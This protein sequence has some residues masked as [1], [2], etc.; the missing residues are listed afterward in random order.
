MIKPLLQVIPALSGNVKLACELDK[1]TQIDDNTFK[2]IC[3]KGHMYPLSS[4]M[5]QSPIDISLLHSSWE[6]DITHFYNVYSDIFF[7]NT[8]TYDKNNILKIYSLGNIIND[9][10]VDVE[11]GC[12][13]VSYQ[14]TNKQLNFF[15]PIYCDNVN[16]IPDYF[17]IT[18]EI[19]NKDLYK[20]K[21]VIRVDL[22]KDNTNH[23]GKYINRYFSKID[24]NVIYMLPSSKQALYYGIDVK[25]GGFNTFVDNIISK[26][27]TYETTVNGYDACISGGFKRN[28]LIIRQIMPLAYYFNI[29]DVLTD[30][31][32]LKY[33]FGTLKISGAYYK[34]GKQLP[35]YKFDDNYEK[36]SLPTKTIDKHTGKFTNVFNY[37]NILN[38]SDHIA[39]ATTDIEEY[40]F[41]NKLNKF[42]NRWILKYSDEKQP[43]ITN[44][45]YLFSKNQGLQNMYYQY[46]QNY[47]WGTALCNIIDNNIN[48]LLPIGTNIEKYYKDYQF[49][50][51]KYL[52]SLNNYVSNWF[53]MT[54]QTDI[55]YILTNT[56]WADVHPDGKLLY[57]GVLYDFNKMYKSL[58]P[59]K[60]KK[61]DKFAILF[62]ID[63]SELFDNSTIKNYI[64]ADGCM[65]YTDS[66]NA[67]IQSNIFENIN[68]GE[69]QTKLLEDPL[70]NV[71]DTANSDTNHKLNY[72]YELNQYFTYNTSG[73]GKY[74]N[75]NDIPLYKTKTAFH[76]NYYEYN[77][78]YE[79]KDTSVNSLLRLINDKIIEPK[80]AKQYKEYIISGYVVLEIPYI[81]NIKDIIYLLRADSTLYFSLGNHNNIKHISELNPN[82]IANT[83]Q[84]YECVFYKHINVIAEKNISRLVYKLN[85]V[86]NNSDIVQD[87]IGTHVKDRNNKFVFHPLYKLDNN[88][89]LNNVFTKIN[90]VNVF[91]EN[92]TDIS[93]LNTDMDLLYVDPYKIKT[94]LEK[95]HTLSGLMYI[96]HIDEKYI[97]LSDFVT[98]NNIQLFISET[99]NKELILNKLNYTYSYVANYNN[100]Y[101]IEKLITDVNSIF[102]SKNEL[103]L[104]SVKNIT[105]SLE[106]IDSKWCPTYSYTEYSKMSSGTVYAYTYDINVNDKL[107][108]NIIEHTDNIYRNN[109]SAYI[110][111]YGYNVNYD[112]N[113]VTLKNYYGY[114]F[115]LQCKDL[116][117][118]YTTA[119]NCGLVTYMKMMSGTYSYITN[120]NG[121]GTYF[122]GHSYM[123]KHPQYLVKTIHNIGFIEQDFTTYDINKIYTNN[124]IKYELCS[125]STV[126]NIDVSYISYINPKLSTTPV[127]LETLIKSHNLDVNNGVRYAKVK[128]KNHLSALFYN[129]YTP[130]N[131]DYKSLCID[132]L[133]LKLHY[134]TIEGGSIHYPEK[135]LFY[136]MRKI[137][138][139]IYRNYNG[140]LNSKLPEI[141]TALE[142][143]GDCI[144]MLPETKEG[145]KLRNDLYDI[146]GVNISLIE[147][148]YKDEFILLSK[149]ILDNVINFNS[150][151]HY[152]D[153]YIYRL[154]K[155]NDLSPDVMFYNQDKLKSSVSNNFEITINNSYCIVPFFNDV[156]IEPKYSTV[157]YQSYI[158]NTLSEVNFTYNGYKT[159]LYRYNVPDK[160]FLCDISSK[161]NTNEYSIIY[162]TKNTNYT[163]YSYQYTLNDKVYT[164]YDPEQLQ[165]IGDYTYYSSDIPTYD[166]YE[167]KETNFVTPS[168]IKYSINN[169]SSDIFAKYKLNT[170][171]Y[172][173][174]NYGFYILD[175]PLNNINS[176][177][178]ITFNDM[179]MTKYFTHI[180][181]INIINNHKYL[182][183][184]FKLLVPIVNYNI[185]TKLY[186][187]PFANNLFKTTFNK[188]YTNI[189]EN[190][191]KHIRV[192]E[193]HNNNITLYRYYDNI[194]PYIYKTSIIENDYA[195][196]TTRDTDVII[197]S[198]ELPYY[199]ITQNIYKYLGIKLFEIQTDTEDSGMVVQKIKE[200]NE[201][202]LKQ[203]EYK[204]FNDNQFINLEPEITIHIGDNLVYDDLIHYQNVEVIKKYFSNYVNNYKRHRFSDDELLF[205]Y[206]KYS[207]ILLSNPIK[208]ANNYNEK[209][210]SLTYKFNLN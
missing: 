149:G 164:I 61:I 107:I 163:T 114:T 74:V 196:K 132:K 148:Y 41:S 128:N 181:G 44:T 183:D 111:A 184:M 92:T 21:K 123:F 141:I 79:L 155:D 13:R 101:D 143:A 192:N 210:Y 179:N 209:I 142:E 135:T 207:V 144:F 9:R 76:N 194:I 84:F 2:A 32:K 25:F 190:G 156:Y 117:D 65:T 10:N 87:F 8:F 59:S 150:D 174:V 133:Y 42:Y 97:T 178:N 71:V 189:T 201:T 82:Y 175:M 60:V 121:I 138:G 63:S 34:D 147:L 81:N 108:T 180:N 131:K 24:D 100:K 134:I 56:K 119:Y 95:Y 125:Y 4:N 35:F 122:Y 157:L 37:D 23:L 203:L 187:I 77:K 67:N 160:L 57:K 118:T 158:L 202:H 50:V 30:N 89:I 152:K 1:Y 169:I 193:Q 93:N 153:F 197:N 46:P 198:N 208:L 104:S 130:S 73:T 146:F 115:E 116:K 98:D 36:L 168:D 39:T 53:D 72:K 91:C 68:K 69:T 102:I 86:G 54:E 172:N 205:L 49:I 127:R 151:E 70:F 94:L 75:I 105:Y 90:N 85:I 166:K 176:V 15:A 5:F 204:F 113:T 51:N 110:Y 11:F 40:K 124:K 29:D 62:H 78:F 31:E 83:K 43:Y 140:E 177:F 165:L 199:K 120:L 48:L 170:Y 33:K 200:S 109:S 55:D 103:T 186:E 3:R 14:K 96:K 16:D 45:N 136:P 64:Y 88:T 126:G 6:Y 185:I 161:Y 19:S 58:N 159:I 26:I 18:V 145:E 22:S 167:I 195:L 188:R 20:T 173:G 99:H 206:N 171:T 27:F 12:K 17:E 162:N 66:T 106:E 112:N 137:M 38:L 182:T 80:D 154:E 7:E 52:L 191:V 47:Y 139:K 28:H 129:I